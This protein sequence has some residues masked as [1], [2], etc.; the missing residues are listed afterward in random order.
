MTY[1]EQI[2][3]GK[4]IVKDRLAVLAAELGRPEIV[5]FDFYRTSND[6][7]KN[8][9]SIQDPKDGKIVVE[10]LIQDLADSPADR[11]VRQRVTTSL[12]TAVRMYFKV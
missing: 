2:L 3:A 11:E 10:L 4:A 5:D 12:D 1:E 9:L 7:D 8:Q 6:F